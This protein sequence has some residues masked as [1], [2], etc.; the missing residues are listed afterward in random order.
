M[1]CDD[2]NSINSVLSASNTIPPESMDEDI[3]L[4]NKSIILA[5]QNKP[6]M[7]A[8]SFGHKKAKTFNRSSDTNYAKALCAKSKDPKKNKAKPA[9]LEDD[10]ALDDLMESLPK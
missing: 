2:S 8:F 1:D 9:N 4:E 3:E 7:H 6:K 5:S 10:R